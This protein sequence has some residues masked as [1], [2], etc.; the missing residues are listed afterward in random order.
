MKIIVVDDERIILTAETLAV[1]RVLPNADVS[2][3]IKAREAIDFAEH[4][5]VDIAF[6]D[7][8]MK[9]MTGLQLAE[10]LQAINPQVNII[11]CTGFAEY[12]LEALDLYCS[13][14]LMKPVTDEKIMKALNKLRYPIVEE[15]ILKVICF[16][17]FE[18]FYGDQPIRFK[19]KKTKELL[20]YLIDRRGTIV[21]TNE[22]VYA[23]YEKLGSESYVR[24]LRSDLTTTFESLGLSE[25]IVRDGR[26]IG[27]NTKKIKC[28]FY[29]Y[30]EGNK[31]LFNGEY[32]TQYGF[33]QSTLAWLIS[34]NT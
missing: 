4:N 18:V 26:N 1:K 24:N 14:Y 8:K 17:D 30:L 27:L 9:G 12:S 29:E 31:T 32:M 33:A 15:P 25:V 6:L 11:F 19:K 7:I 28:D 22:I 2:S 10:Q 34:N 21:S 3:F 16:G 20:A 13:A 5:K 23:L